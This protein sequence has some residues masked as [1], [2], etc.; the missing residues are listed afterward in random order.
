MY[1]NPLLADSP[2]GLHYLPGPLRLLDA[3]HNQLPVARG[4]TA[5]LAAYTVTVQAVA[6]PPVSGAKSP[7]V[8]YAAA[9]KRFA[10]EPAAVEPAVRVAAESTVE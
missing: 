4:H 5:L 2:R 10:A 1:P 6:E 3:L 9:L 8:E 7:V